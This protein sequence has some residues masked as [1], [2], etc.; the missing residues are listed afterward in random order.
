MKVK[1]LI[2]R[3][4]KCNPEAF[5]TIGVPD[6]NSDYVRR[7]TERPACLLYFY[8]E[9]RSDCSHTAYPHLPAMEEAVIYASLDSTFFRTD[10]PEILQDA[11]RGMIRP[12]FGP[13][14]N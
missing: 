2:E 14:S 10:D 1:Q 4:Q 5:V 7:L 12:D 13:E 6:V 3:L 11:E 9:Q 8:L